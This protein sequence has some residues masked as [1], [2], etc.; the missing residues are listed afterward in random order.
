MGLAASLLVSCFP[1]RC[2]VLRAAV[3]L[4]LVG[5]AVLLLVVWLWASLLPSLF[6]CCWWLLGAVLG[7]GLRLLWCFGAAVA[8]LRLLGWVLV[9]VLLSGFW[10]VFLLAASAA[11]RRVA[12]GASGA[13]VLA[14]LAVHRAG[15]FPLVS[16]LL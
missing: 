13:S 7:I 10:W 16:V 1:S 4:G 9:A 15:V 12:V 14:V 3:V 6:R 5:V 11:L 2:L 8:G